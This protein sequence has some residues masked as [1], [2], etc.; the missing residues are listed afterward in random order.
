MIQIKRGATAS[1][2]KQKQPL[3]AGQP[4]YDKDK[5]KL[6]IGD[7]EKSWDELP[8]AGGPSSEEILSSETEAKLRRSAAT[9]LS[10]LSALFDSPAIITYGTESPD[11]NTVGQLYLQCY[12]AEPETDYIV[13]SG[14]N[15]GWSYQ[16]WKSGLAS[17]SKVFDVT[18]SIQTSVDGDLYQNTSTID[19][20]DY[21]FSFKEI[22]CEI[23]TIQSPG[24]LVWLAAS[25][26][27]NTKKK[28]ASYSLISKDKLFDSATYRISLK[29][30]GFWR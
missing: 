27:L 10:P 23:A 20:Q 19:V 7:G 17:C 14:I 18:T 3:A 12:D 5:H 6:K 21:P 2:K 22:P 13:E 16:K 29:V 30:E 4:G 8:Y 25:T 9:S 1:W 15:S 28:S 24:G 11:E 26:K